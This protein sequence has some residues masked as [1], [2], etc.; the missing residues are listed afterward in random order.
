MSIS[1]LY[2]QFT[3][4]RATTTA[5][6]QDLAPTWDVELNIRLRGPYSLAGFIGKSTDNVYENHGG[7]FRIDI[8]GFFFI[9][10][11]VLREAA[12]SQ[13]KYPVSTSAF[14]F[15]MQQTKNDEETGESS[16]FTGSIMGMS[17]DVFLF[18]PYSFL[19]VQASFFNTQGHAFFSYSYGV[20]FEY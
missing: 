3:D 1:T 19:T 13:R 12:R 2:S 20:G 10:G 5:L 7:G 4:L 11:N 6:P 17:M 14:G 18:N 8:P 16:R 9:G 15:L